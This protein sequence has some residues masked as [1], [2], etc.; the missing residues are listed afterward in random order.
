MGNKIDLTK[1][2]LKERIISI[3]SKTKSGALDELVRAFCHT[4]KYLNKSKIRDEIEKRESEMSSIVMEGLALPHLHINIKKDL[5]IAI[6][7]SAEGIDYFGDGSKIIYV[8]IMILSREELHEL[9]LSVLAK[10]SKI[11]SQPDFLTGIKQARDAEEII[12]MF[13]GREKVKVR[14]SRVSE[15]NK[16][17]TNCVVR[18][19]AEIADELTIKKVLINCDQISDI[20]ILK[21]LEKH[22][23]IP[24]FKD[25]FTQSKDFEKKFGDCIHIPELDLGNAGQIKLALFIGIAK[26]LIH[27]QDTLIYI[28]PGRGLRGLGSIDVITVKERFQDVVHFSTDEFIKYVDPPVLE[29]VIRIACGLGMY[30]REGK[31][32]GTMFVIGDHTRVSNISQQLILNPFRQS[33]DGTEQWNILDPAV[34]G[35][36]KELSLLDGGFVIEGN[37]N[38]ISAATY[39][40][41]RKKKLDI[42]KGLGTRHQAA[43]NISAVTKAISVVVS[44]TNGNV[45][46]F[47]RGKIIIVVERIVQ[48]ALVR[49]VE[50]TQS[51]AAS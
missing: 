17:I 35:M 24:V 5:V 29:R 9:H 49:K 44:E 40:G 38:I 2:V 4:E 36:V 37:G 18:K 19:S 20:S 51:K 15:R 12:N 16:E 41:T 48:D 50:S 6:G 42:P 27:K 43:A 23:I 13:N 46:V 14:M 28:L 39:I 47:H 45:T 21:P 3:K 31:K 7:R 8:I 33:A 22:R 34:E 10:I 1:Y 30:G 25:D 26:K 11:I 32:V